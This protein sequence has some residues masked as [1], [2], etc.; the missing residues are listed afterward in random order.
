MLLGGIVFDLRDFV[1]RGIFDENE[2]DAVVTFHD[3]AEAFWRRTMLSNPPLEPLLMVSGL[4]Q[5]R[6]R[7]VGAVV[8][9]QP[10]LDQ[11]LEKAK[12][13]AEAGKHGRN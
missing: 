10:R 3:A 9:F 7:C 2:M 1:E 5:L 8:G 4:R 11:A 6:D 12:S 13:F